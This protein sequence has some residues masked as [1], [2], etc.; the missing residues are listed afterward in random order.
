MLIQYFLIFLVL[1]IVYRTFSRWK[2]GSLALK[3]FIFWLC[4]WAIA[5]VVVLKPESTDFVANILGV[6]RGADM[7]VYLSIILLF[8]IVFQTTIKIEKIERN[9]TK[10]VREMAIQKTTGDKQQTTVNQQPHDS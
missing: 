2:Q 5:C 10:I 8:Y 6:G 7:V 4:F 9:I 1:A 3:K